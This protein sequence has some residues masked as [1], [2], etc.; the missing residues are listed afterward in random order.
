VPAL[1]IEHEVTALL[2]VA[3][4]MEE[5]EWIPFRVPMNVREQVASHLG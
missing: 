1:S 3:K 5:I 2:E 4:Q